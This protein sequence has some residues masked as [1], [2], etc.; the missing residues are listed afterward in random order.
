MH[1]PP[2]EKLHQVLTCPQ[3]LHA[4]VLRVMVAGCILVLLSGLGP[5]LPDAAPKVAVVA[6]ATEKQSWMHQHPLP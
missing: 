2:P 6:A 5:G 4:A 1:V 3:L